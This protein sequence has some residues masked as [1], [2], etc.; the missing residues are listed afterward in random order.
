[1]IEILKPGLHT[2]VQ[3]EGR[4]GHRSEGI[5]VS[6]AMDQ[7]S[8]RFANF[9]LN[10][11]PATPLL[12]FTQ[13]GPTLYF[14]ARTTA[15]L[16]GGKYHVE[17]DGKKVP[18]STPFNVP[19][20]ST[21][22][23]GSN[24]SGNYGY[25]SIEGGF[26]ALEILGSASYCPNVNDS[27]FCKKGNTF[28]FIRSTKKHLS[29]NAQVSFDLPKS[30]YEIEVE[31]GPDYEMLTEEEKEK[32]ITGKYTIGRNSSRMAIELDHKYTFGVAD[33]ITAPVQ[34][35]TVQLTPAGNLVVLMRDAQTTGGYAR[36]LQLSESS[37]NRIANIG[38]GKEL[39]FRISQRNYV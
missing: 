13:Q 26:H 3:D 11:N 9:L 33:I 30:G 34:P 38:I 29:K 20:G 18:F 36:V 8:Y 6:G 22:K 24:I 35:G 27:A 17:L 10:N 21:L 31:Q 37:I 1:M 28:V 7:H 4:I 39:K 32:L 23:I 25:L 5:P 16:T 19:A 15:V 14:H 2:T 12:E